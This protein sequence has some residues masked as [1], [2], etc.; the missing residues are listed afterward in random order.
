MMT[1]NQK[2]ICPY[3]T[4]CNFYPYCNKLHL[5]T[6]CKNENCKYYPKCKYSHNQDWSDR[7]VS[8]WSS[9]AESRK[10]SMIQKKLNMKYKKNLRYFHMI[11]KYCYDN[12]ISTNN[13]INILYVSVTDDNCTI[14]WQFNCWIPD[15]PV[16][17][18]DRFSEILIKSDSKKFTDVKKSIESYVSVHGKVLNMYYFYYDRTYNPQ[19]FISK[20]KIE[21]NDSIQ[22]IIEL[23]NP[24]NAERLKPGLKII[25]CK[26]NNVIIQNEDQL[27]K[28]DLIFVDEH[29]I[30]D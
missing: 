16:R 17:C 15:D 24:E 9:L 27:S 10:G 7:A 30:D 5:I 25:H 11:S 2:I 4:Q 13:D 21:M 23:T 1:T 3:G 20:Q 26:E 18:F 12:K 19:Q 29:Y 6:M 22:K 8:Q 28:Y 14:D